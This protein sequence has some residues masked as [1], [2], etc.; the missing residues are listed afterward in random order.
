MAKMAS[1]CTRV[2]SDVKESAEAVLNQLGMSMSTAMEVYLR[3]IA[4]QRKIPFEMALP[5]K[6]PIAYDCLSDQEFDRLMTESLKEYENG[7][8]MTAEELKSQLHK[9]LGV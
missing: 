9:E 1:I 3:Q 8:C 4:Y 2:D 6:R 5:D 7:E